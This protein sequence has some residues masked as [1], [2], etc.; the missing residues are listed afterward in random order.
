MQ[1][2]KDNQKNIYYFKKSCTIQW[3]VQLLQLLFLIT[4]FK[5]PTIIFHNLS[6]PKLS[7]LLLRNPHVASAL[8]Y[9]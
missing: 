8:R 2:V 9:T 4:L 5:F 6:K 3:N 7:G 1:K